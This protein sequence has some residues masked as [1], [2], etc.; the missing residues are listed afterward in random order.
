MPVFAKTPFSVFMWSQE[1]KEKQNDT[2]LE[3][4]PLWILILTEYWLPLWKMIVRIQRKV[5]AE[6]KQRMTKE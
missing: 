1:K 3:F 5:Y 4:F 2:H 6:E